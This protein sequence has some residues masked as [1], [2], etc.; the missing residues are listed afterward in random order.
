MKPFASAATRHH[1]GE[2]AIGGGL[3]GGSEL[4]LDDESTHGESGHSGELALD[5]ESAHGDELALT[6]GLP[7]AGTYGR[8]A[9][10]G[11]AAGAFETGPGRAGRSG[12]G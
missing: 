3:A 8:V 5:G 1:A 7:L 6:E 12:R 11:L 10:S 2:L 4:A 9:V